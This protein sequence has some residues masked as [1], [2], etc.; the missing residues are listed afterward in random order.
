MRPMLIFVTTFQVLLTCG[1]CNGS[2]SLCNKQYSEVSY[3]TTHNAYNCSNNGFNLPNQYLSITE[4]LN[5]GVRGFMIDVYDIFGTVSVYHGTFA[6]GSE[7]LSVILQEFNTF[8]TAY[9]NEVLT[10][11]LECY[12]SSTEI[13]VEFSG[14]GLLNKLYSHNEGSP[15]PT[16]QQL[17]NDGKNIVL[18]TDQND[19]LPS[20]N[21]YNYMWTNMVETHYSVD[22]PSLFTHDFNRGDSINDLFIFNHFVTDPVFG[23]GL[24]AEASTVNEFNFLMDRIVENY[25]LKQKF[26]NFITLDV[27]SI[28]DGLQVVN[29]LN[30][31][32]LKT[33]EIDRPIIK[34]YPNPTSMKLYLDV[35]SDKLNERWDISINDISG[36]SLYLE[37]T[38]K[39]NSQVIDVSELDRGYYILTIS[40]DNNIFY[41]E[42]IILK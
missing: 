14:A 12:V 7:P 37:Q 15:W 33:K 4:Q 31:N 40:M 38:S 5:L 24:E 22:S 19:A 13:E 30:Q 23:V 28:G 1:Q 17:I 16:L 2:L 20:Q 39:F 9:P 36:R 27:V 3:L 8:L 29:D 18:F 6:L 10:I 34:I 32:G 41:S 42:K 11:I 26:P 21:W 35:I 25:S